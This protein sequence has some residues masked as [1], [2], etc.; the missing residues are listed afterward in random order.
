MKTKLRSLG[1]ITTDLE[2]LLLEM[3]IDHELQIHEILGIIK[4]YLICHCPNSI[5]QYDD[6][7]IPVYYY[8][9]QEFLGKK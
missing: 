6:G 7:T 3:A 9:H 4:A 5:E 2:P 8:G 1:K